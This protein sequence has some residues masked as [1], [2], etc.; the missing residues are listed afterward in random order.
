M[1]RSGDIQLDAKHSGETCADW[2]EFL[3]QLNFLNHLERVR[4]VGSLASKFNQHNAD[5]TVLDIWKKVLYGMPDLEGKPT[6]T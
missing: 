2:G 6:L 5:C 4:E 3:V 1:V